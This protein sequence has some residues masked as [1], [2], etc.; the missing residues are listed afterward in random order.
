MENLL[1]MKG[2]SKSFFGVKV[3]HE[4]DFDVRAGEVVALCGENGAGKSTLV[5]M[6][7]AI[8]S[9]D[10]GTITIQGKEIPHMT[11]LQM[12]REGVSIIHQ[13][14]QLLEDMTVAQNIFLTREPKKFGIIDYPRMNREAK[15]LLR[16]LG[17]NI[18]PASKVK[19][20]KIAQKQM[21]EIARAIS[22]DVKVIIMDEPTAVLTLVEAEILFELIKSLTAGGIGVIYVSHRLGEVKRI[23]DRVTI[24]RD[25]H[26]VATRDVSDV[27][28][29]EIASLMVGRDVD[30]S[31]AEDFDGNPGDIVLEVRGITGDILKE[32]NFSVARGEIVGFCGLVGAGRSELMEMI[33]GLRKFKAGQVL[34]H[35]RPVTIKSAKTAISA[36]LGFATEDRKGTGLVQNRSISENSDFAFRVKYKG[37]WILLPKAIRSRAEAM[38]NR[39]SV[40]CR[41]PNQLVKHLSGGNQQKV[42]LAKWLSSDPDILIVDEPTRGIDV[43]ARAEIYDIIKEL[44]KE[45]KTIIMVSSDMTEVLGIC[46]R[47]IIIH[48]G[49]ITGVLTGSARTED[50]IMHHVVNVMH[51]EA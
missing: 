30:D 25:G 6:L 21:V 44:A 50:N 45:G 35:G 22:F 14:L 9:R 15:E 49:K 4:V 2:M 39:L 37:N 42:V 29:R 13:E 40:A 20:L 46:Q 28:E 51:Q 10:E 17:Q 47:V 36:G 32:V 19:T 16:R 26:L 24:L 27:T 43:G 11:P 41:G 33:F 3:L 8:Y 34:L 31:V 18:D 5:N 12:Q 48:E 1:E 23:A 38:I 7:A